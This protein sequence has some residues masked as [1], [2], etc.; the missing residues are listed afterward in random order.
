MN[1]ICI[2]LF[3][4][5]VGILS[6]NASAVVEVPP[7]FPVATPA[8]ARTHGLDDL[9]SAIRA[10]G[11]VPTPDLSDVLKPGREA[12]KAFQQLGKLLFW[13]QSV[14]SKGQACASC[15]FHAGADSRS[16]NQMSPGLLRVVNKRDGDIV[17]FHNAK[18]APDTVFQTKQPNQQL[19]PGDF[20]FIKT[21]QKVVDV[22]SIQEPFPGNSN[23]VASSMGV[24]RE[25]FI[26]VRPGL[27]NDKCEP[28]DDPVFTT[29]HGI[30]VR[31]VEPRHTPTTHNAVLNAFNFWDGRA[32]HFFNGQNPF[33]VQDPD[34]R[35]LVFEGDT[36][37]KKQVAFPNSALASQ[38]VGPPLSDF[39]MSCGVPEKM[40]A[41]T[42]PEI[43]KKLLR[44]RQGV[45]ITPLQSQFI[46]PR[47]SLIGN[48]SK[49]PA[50][51]ANVKY[52]KLIK[53]AFKQKYWRAPGF[54]VIFD[55]VEIIIRPPGE[56]LADPVGAQIVAATPL[57]A[58]QDAQA[59]DA[60]VVDEAID[61]PAISARPPV[62][63]RFTLM[64]ANF[65]LFFG[66]SVQAY[67]GLLLADNSWF[68]RWMRTGNFNQGFGTPEVKGL[69]V[70]VNKGKCINCH[71]GPELTNASVRNFQR[72]NNLIEPMLMGDNNFAIYDNGFYNI[73]VTP[74]ADDVGRGGKGP[75]GAPLA[76]SRQRLFEENGIMKIP[77]KIIGRDRI[78]AVTE[79]EGEPVCNDVD[80]DG[81]C[82]AKEPLFPKFQRAAVDGAMKTSG[83]RNIRLQGPY[84]HNGSMASLRQV[85][86]FYDNGGNFCRNNRPDL[87]PDIQPLGLSDAEKRQLVKF[88][89]SLTDRR[90]TFQKAPFDHPSLIVP[91]NGRKGGAT[92]K[93]AAVGR[94]GS[95]TALNTFLGLNPQFIG[96]S[97]VDAVC[98]KD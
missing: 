26:K 13:E 95:A 11:G 82:S 70:F 58:Q 38:A 45:A 27:P 34:A 76:S 55:G 36:I 64:E 60:A 12:K 71:G 51:G 2:L 67:Q 21:I 29:I 65:S 22:N 9:R 57:E 6:G 15:H 83:L 16:R 14:G 89:I 85:V 97:P 17:G 62:R 84:F 68:D 59:P 48:L 66:L 92:L 44:K 47:D 24:L 8:D 37:K 30:K 53:T 90:V 42:W 10:D 73:S 33:G 96:Q 69:N 35:I 1:K 94:G 86:E 20:P 19:Q 93:I 77:F 7:T 43:G 49:A 87:D 5:T 72:G 39:E 78:P 63:P 88:L 28:V 81:F 25:L 79:D 31:R 74:T 32:N 41:R 3:G 23:D 61:V 18:P 56:G 98:S 4:V 40:N 50:M 75:T 46:H 91:R 52:R 54:R 80:G